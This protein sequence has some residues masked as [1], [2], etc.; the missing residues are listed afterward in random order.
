MHT[1][2]YLSGLIDGEGSICLTKE[3]AS[4]LYRHPRVII[5]STT[6]ELMEWLKAHFGGTVSSKKKY[7]EHHLQSW[8]WVVANRNAVDL[9]RRV[10]ELLI[11]PQKRARALLIAER[12][13]EVTK[14]NGK[15][16]LAEK[17][18]KV[19]FQLQFHQL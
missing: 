6:P 12:Y 17:A 1:L 4:A 5:P 18:A 13:N 8:N 9:C 10:W 14:R 7:Q 15:Y 11:V 3:R 2:S 19:D 16:T